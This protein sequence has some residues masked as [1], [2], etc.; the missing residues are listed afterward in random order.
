MNRRALCIPS[1]I[2]LALL[3]G[4]S[5]VVAG[6][7]SAPLPQPSN[8]SCQGY[9]RDTVVVYWKDEASDETN[10]RVERSIG[11]GAWTE[12]A[13]LT[14]DGNGRYSPYRD[15]GADVSTQN[16]RYRVRAFRSTD[17]SYS[18]Y[19]AVCNNR[20]IYEPGDFRI[21]YGLRGTSDDCPQVDGHDACLADLSSGGNNVYVTRVDEA[22]QGSVDAFTRLGFAKSA[23]TPPGS[24]D[25]VPINV[26]WCDGGGCAG[27]GGLGVAP[28]LL[29]T[30]FDLNTRVGDPVAWLMPLHELFHFQQFKYWGLNDPADKWVVEGQARSIQDKICIGANRSTAH[31][32][33]DIATGDGGYVPEVVGY[34]ANPNRPITQISY[35]T[36]LFWT[37]LTE[38]YGTSAPADPAEAGMDLMLR[39]WESSN[40]TP[41]RDGISVLNSTLTGLGHTQ[42]FRDIWKDFAVANYAK[43]LSGP[44]VP[45]KYRY[46]DMSQTGGNYGPVALA[47]DQALNA[48]DG[49]ID[50]DETVY[51][52]AARYYQVRPAATVPLIHIT[53]TQDSA[54]PLYYTLL[55]I[56][57]NDIAY[58]QHAESRHFTRA[59]ANNSYDRVVL[60]VA[61]LESL[62]NY[63]YSINGT[64][65]T[66]NILDPTSANKARV[67]DPSAPDKFRVALEVL[68]SSGSPMSG[69]QLSDFQF[70]VGT[71]A[72]PASS[73]L[74]S[75][76]VMSQQWFVLRAPVQSSAGG[77]DLQVTYSGLVTGTET[78]AVNYAP[79]TDADNLLLID[80][81]GSMSVL[82]KLP[83]A[84]ATARLFVD[85][86]RPGDKIGVISFNQT[87]NVELSLRDWTT[88][89]VT[90]G[91]RQEAFDAIDGLTASGGTNIGDTLRT[92]W[93]ELNSRGDAAHDWALVLLSDGKEEASSPTETF[94]QMIYR[95]QTATSKRPAVHTVAVGADADRVRMQRLAAVTNGTYQYVSTPAPLFT[96]YGTTQ[97]DDMQLNLDYRYRMIASDVAGMQPAFSLVGPL[98]DN[99]PR[100]DVVE[101]PIEGSASEL[102]LSLSWN[103]GIEYGLT[104]PGGGPV[105]VFEFDNH[106]AIWR[107]AAPE[108]GIWTLTIFPFD[109]P[110]LVQASLR[111]D[112]TMD[113]Y[114]PTPLAD[115]VPGAPMPI[116]AS[117]TDVRPITGATVV[118]HVELP[119]GGVLS[120]VLWDDGAHA[121]GAPG[122]GLYGNTLYQTGMPGSYSVT[123]QGWGTSEI[124][125]DFYREKVLSFHLHSAGDRDDDGLPD[126]WE[127]RQGTDPDVPDADA[128]PDNDSLPNIDELGRGTNP[129][130]PDSDD[131]GEADGTDPDPHDR[132]DDG[133]SP[134]WSAAY[135]LLDRVVLRYAL[136]PEY[137]VIGVFR[138]DNLRGPFGF[139]AMDFPPTG[140]FT[141]TQVAPGATYCY[142]IVGMDEMGRQSAPLAPACATP[143]ADP[144]PPHGRVLINGGAPTTSSPQVVLSLWASD[145]VDPESISPGSEALLPPA[146]SATE[147][148]EMMI[149]NGGDFGGSEWEPYQR[150]RTW[151]LGQTHGLAAVFV[152]YR[153]ATG[154]V[155]EPA[156]ATI[157]VG[158]EGP[159]QRL[160]LP[161]IRR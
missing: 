86:W 43:D 26:V 154:N 149:S 132:A 157:H 58:E 11:G 44:G 16:R 146:D 66:L 140:I 143:R 1:F 55:G 4:A 144:Y 95:L 121:D 114:L 59:L 81:S 76:T 138:G 120:F 32:F 20:H 38:Q 103:G 63:R 65:P 82:N 153:D 111:S 125:G 119:G 112:V 74:V 116:L 113:V 141:D 105:R 18:P 83:A 94:D 62:A 77:Y 97:V 37:Y 151:T 27:G 29:E 159:G 19:S 50:A 90:G 158:G 68:T 45:A 134:T 123:V 89:T 54:V 75:A 155:S 53:V 99:D 57:G 161:V 88:N 133:I 61:G 70:R 42:R 80:H 130:D 41:G 3:T 148:T 102:V 126:E 128:D 104:G 73:I 39:F 108:P 147:V 6:R 24:L 69:V 7:D 47:L 98:A 51:P 8:I 85:S 22:L 14:P 115:R 67:G 12:I 79:R 93:N 129:R 40:A 28:A 72:V 136:R 142:L 150:E 145:A 91:S 35:A 106:H 21:F 2:L 13:T 110:Y 107:V 139:H 5:V 160:L 17:T 31:C 117:L 46:T 87:P 127:Q 109:S 33:D 34:L 137:Q 25:K 124:S 9:E 60:I 48:G 30:A 49:I 96:T 118:A 52:W 152:R 135:P 92:G 122:D 156:V 71:Q 100:R 10:Y 15:T 101:I 78:Q 131:G 56:K 23:A 64:Q 84:Q 36:A